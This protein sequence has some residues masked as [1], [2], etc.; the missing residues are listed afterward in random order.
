MTARVEHGAK[1]QLRILNEVLDL[2][3]MGVGKF[4]IDARPMSLATVATLRHRGRKR[5]GTGEG[6]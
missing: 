1:V 5:G 6:Y 3:H 4:R 2:A